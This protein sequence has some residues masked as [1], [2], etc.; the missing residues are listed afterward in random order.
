M[1]AIPQTDIIKKI[2]EGCQF[3]TKRYTRNPK[4][5]YVESEDED[6]I[7]FEIRTISKH[8]KESFK[9]NSLDN[10]SL[11]DT[12]LMDQTKST[13]NTPKETGLLFVSE[14]KILNQY[15]LLRIT[16]IPF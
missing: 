6:S 8:N 2:D 4:P 12:I 11:E 14:E 1:D 15:L 7:N 16:Y 9:L 13:K 3:S 10:Q 5:I